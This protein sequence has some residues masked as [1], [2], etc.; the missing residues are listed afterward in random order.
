LHPLAG[1]FSARGMG[2]ADVRWQEDADGGRRPLDDESLRALEPTW[3]AL[4]E[5]VRRVLEDEGFRED[6]VLE[7]TAELR[8]RGTETGLEVPFADVSEMRARFEEAHRRWFGYAREGR[9]VEIAVVRVS[10]TG[11]VPIA[12]AN[13]P[14]V[15]P[16]AERTRS[17][18]LYA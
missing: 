11:R 12:R 5:R 15:R 16:P 1:V 2:L 6:A 7:R 14:R 3:R 13:V 8:Y 17:T 18:A 4:E 9:T 10:G